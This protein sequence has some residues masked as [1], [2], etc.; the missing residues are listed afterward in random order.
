MRLMLPF[1]IKIVDGVAVGQHDGII[2]PFAAQDIH[3]E[4]VACATRLTFVTVVSTHHLPDIPLLHQSLESRQISFPQVAHRHGGVVRMPQWF[5]TTVHR[6]MLGAGVCLI[7][8]AV[9]ALH[10]QDSLHTQHCIHIRVLSTRLLSSSPSR[11]A[12]DIDIGA[13]KRQFRVSW[14]VCHP[15]R[16]IKDIVV[17][18]VPIGTRLIGNGGKHVV[19]QLAVE[20]CRHSN[21]LRIDRIPS[22]SHSVACLAPPV[23]GRYSQ[24]VDRNRLV[25]HQPHLLLWREQRDEILHTLLEGEIDILI[26]EGM[27]TNSAGRRLLD[28]GFYRE[29]PQGRPITSY[30][31]N[32]S[33]GLSRHPLRIESHHHLSRFP[34][35]DVLVCI[36]SPDAFTTWQRLLY[37]HRRLGNILKCK[38]MAYSPV[39]LVNSAEIPSVSIERNWTFPLSR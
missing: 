22:L 29:S 32:A 7:I 8:P 35:K 24:P 16:Y 12:E 25:H 11:V 19:K 23:V 39:V 6:I 2:S 37:L 36:K 27:S 1:V 28:N 10:S 15:H 34:R 38:R 18:A 9:V 30:Q 13:P 33:V 21:G 20:R 14:I 31:F 3:Q 5:G 17:G 4:P 26:G